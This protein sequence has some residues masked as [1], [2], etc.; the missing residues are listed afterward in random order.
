MFTNQRFDGWKLKP[1]T[2]AGLQQLGWENATQ[3]QRDTVPIA[4]S[5]NDVIG[6]ARTGSGKT[7]AFGIPTVSY[8]HLRAHETR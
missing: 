3:V 7:G 1:S 2:L 6:Q 5:G 4:L 8:T